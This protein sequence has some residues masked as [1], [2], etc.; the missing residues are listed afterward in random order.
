MSDWRHL[1]L[2]KLAEVSGV[3]GAANTYHA[4]F[5]L[6]PRINAGGRVGQANLGA[7]L[8]S[9]TDEDEA[10][11]IAI[12]LDRLNKERRG[13]ESAVMDEA[14]AQI[15]GQGASRSIL[16][17]TGEGWHPGVIGVVAGRLKEKYAKPC[18][19][20]ALN[21]DGETPI[22]K[23]SGRSVAG[24]N[25]GGA[26]SAARDAGLL[27]SG[28]GHAM[29]G[30]LSVDP[31]RIT[32]LIAFL[33]ERLTPEL[34]KSGDAM[35]LKLDGLISAAGIDVDL[36]DVLDQAAPYGQG[37][38]EPRFAIANI[39]VNYAQ[40]VGADHVRF[41]LEDRDLQRISG[42]AFRCADSAMGQALLAADGREWHAAGRLKIN[43]WKG[44]KSVQFQLED[45]AAV[46]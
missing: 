13:I 10:T 27:I 11:R 26:I 31:D 24:V 45:L 41:T 33:D 14:L 37:H 43:E 36:I 19:I 16:V 5:L 3:S 21:R 30:G 20:I 39:K 34:A 18:L 6:G 29:A 15:E 23:G 46:K 35:A 2:R 17:A 4:G 22:G 25:L 9:T 1:G 28:G 42:I 32:E 7:R 40:L 8:L 38:S 44:R 12:E